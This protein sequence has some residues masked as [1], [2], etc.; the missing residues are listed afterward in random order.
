MEVYGDIICQGLLDK[1]HKITIITARNS[2]RNQENSVKNKKIFYLFG[3]NPYKYTKKWWDKSAKKFVE[4]AKKENFDLIWSQSAGALSWIRFLR[5]KYNIPCVATIHGTPFGEIKT[6]FKNISS[7][8]SF[9]RLS[10]SFLK[11][12]YYKL[13]WEKYY[14]FLSAAIVVSENII[15]PFHKF[16]SLD[17]DKIYYIPNGVDMNLYSPI[18][19]SEDSKQLRKKHLI[20]AEERVLLAA[21][22]LER[23]K[24]IQSIIKA[25][26][27]IIA[28][29]PK[30][31][32]LIIGTGSYE[33]ELKTLAK[34]MG[35]L[36]HVIFCGFINRENLPFYY[37]ISDV[38][39]MPTQR[40]EGF[41]FVIAEAMACGR[42]IVASRIG[43]IPSAIDDGL[44]GILIPPG[45]INILAEKIILLLRNK[46]LSIKLA[47]NARKKALRLFNQEKMIT[48]TI[49]IFENCL[50]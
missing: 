36:N 20:Y 13:T 41:P 38:F 11:N 42:T 30:I 37:N 19:N 4:I 48:K 29:V 2:Y 46:E 3:V 18:I 32:L 27:R 28:S 6:K 12:I 40:H 17:K 15:K 49:G 9:F 16:Y 7:P 24:G 50:K 26:P 45:N 21:G 25:L 39:L 33:Q 43:G 1:G 44:N 31:K 14:R 35:I 22:R 10:L 34:K 47:N 23:E 8:L 5:T